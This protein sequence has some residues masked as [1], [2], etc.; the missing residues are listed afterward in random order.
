MIMPEKLTCKK[1]GADLSQKDSVLREY[2]NKGDAPSKTASGHY[3]SEGYFD[4]DAHIDLSDGQYDLVDGS[5]TCVS[6]STTIQ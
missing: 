5:D 2:I 3:D 4:P 6:C 1:C